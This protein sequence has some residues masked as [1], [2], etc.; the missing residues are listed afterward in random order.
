MKESPNIYSPETKT[1]SKS[2]ELYGL[3]EAKKNNQNI[4]TLFVVE[5][6]MDVIALYENGIKNAV[7]SLGTAITGLHI[8]KLMRYAKQIYVTFDGDL[9]GRKAAWRAVENA[10]PI[11]REDIK[12]SF[13]FL[14]EGQDPD[15]YVNENG[16]DEFL[17]L[18]NKSIPLSEFFIQ[19]LKDKDNLDSLEGRTNVAKFALPYIKSINNFF[20]IL[21]FNF[22]NFFSCTVINFIIIKGKF[23]NFF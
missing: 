9:A 22:F 19:T 5:G 11:L 4:D 18:T 15:S 23:F 16:K 1:F 17:K 8:S 2:K 13:I 3:Y 6:Y 10:L 7:A 12:M 14:D 21:F 20:I